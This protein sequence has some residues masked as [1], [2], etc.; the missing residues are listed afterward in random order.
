MYIFEC[1]HNLSNYSHIWFVTSRF[2]V[3]RVPVIKVIDHRGCQNVVR[4]HRLMCHFFVHILN[5]E[6]VI[7]E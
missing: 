6:V 4:T 3:L 2:H 5:S 1:F 7:T